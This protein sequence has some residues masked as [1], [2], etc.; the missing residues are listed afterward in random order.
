LINLKNADAE[1]QATAVSEAV[2]KA[3]AEMTSDTGA[4]EDI[5]K[6]HAEELQALE[7]KLKVHHES[8]VKARVDAALKSRPAPAANSADQQAVV[9]AALAEFEKKLQQRHTEEIASA[10]ERGRM[11]QGA[12]AKLKDSQLVKAQ[13]RVKDLEAQIHEWQAA[14]IVLP[15]TAAA[16]TP[17]GAAPA[18]APASAKPTPSAPQSQALTAAAAAGPSQPKP[19]PAASAVAATPAGNLPR[20]PP[21]NTPG[22]QTA[23]QPG[24]GGAIRGV[25]RGGFIQRGGAALRQ[26]PVRTAPTAPPAT[27]GVSIIG[28]AKRPREENPAITEDSLAKRLKPAQPS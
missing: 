28:A 23:L 9:D 16:S 8:E 2:E 10:V 1:K 4:Q 25:G 12:K 15:P 3:K 7:Q 26:P 11:E 27:Q 21:A 5:S 24:R 19:N 14:G 6:R 20:K 18:Q 17:A 13:K 22:T